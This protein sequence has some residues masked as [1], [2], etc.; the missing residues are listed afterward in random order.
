LRKPKRANTA[1]LRGLPSTSTPKG[2]TPLRKNTLGDDDASRWALETHHKTMNKELLAEQWKHEE[3]Q[4]FSGWDFSY[5]TNRML[6][7]QP[8]WS[9][10]ARAIEL[11][12]QS[13]SVIDLDTGGGERFM[14]L[15]EHW[16]PNLSQ[17]D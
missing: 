17:S 14:E 1:P 2:H 5:L 4:P 10:P 15:R 11:M 8:D 12:K 6:E 7:E 13:S 16:P 9:Y 3:E